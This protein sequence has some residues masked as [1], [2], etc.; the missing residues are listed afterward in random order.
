MSDSQDLT[1]DEVQRL[2]K[3]ARAAEAE[4]HSASAVEMFRLVQRLEPNRQSAIYRAA[5]SL[6]EIGRLQDADASL[7]TLS[8][9]PEGKAW[10]VELLLGKLRMAQFRPAEAQAH[11]SK[12][13]ELNP[14]TTE[15]AVF[16]GNCLYQQEKFNEAV[17]VLMT[18]L[19]CQGDL[20]EV[21][22]NLGLVKRA[23]GEYKQARLYL[24][25][26]LKLNPRYR[27]A[28]RV[29]SDVELCLEV[30][31]KTKKLKNGSIS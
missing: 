8:Q 15:P 22:L 6:L 31:Q 7:R 17:D 28:K 9:P 14:S 30:L 18:A 10:L 27:D 13:R 25:K 20:D 16:L 11:F 23:L 26:A 24:K 4:G 5:I 19:R 2:S 3:S 1:R 12:A 29:L 21:Y